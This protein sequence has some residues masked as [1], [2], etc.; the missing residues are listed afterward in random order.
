MDEV[1]LASF[2]PSALV[3]PASSRSTEHCALVIQSWHNKLIGGQ[4]IKW[5]QPPPTHRN[6]INSIMGMDAVEVHLHLAIL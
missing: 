2:S 4:R 5:I 1:A 6:K 3:F